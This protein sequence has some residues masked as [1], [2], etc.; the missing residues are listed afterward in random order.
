MPDYPTA[1]AL[2]KQQ[3]AGFL[4][5]LVMVSCAAVVL[6][7]QARKRPRLARAL[8]LA[9]PGLVPLLT[10]LYSPVAA[11]GTILAALATRYAAIP[12][13]RPLWGVLALAAA[14]R[15]PL[16]FNS[17]WYDEAFTSRL[18]HL[19][20]QNLPGAIMADVHPPLYYL[21]LWPL[22]QLTTSP[23]LLRLPSLLAGL[24]AIWLV[25]WLVCGMGLGER[26][27][28]VTSLLWAVLPASIYYATELRSYQLLVVIVLGL[29]LAII[30]NRPRWFAVLLALLPWLHNVGFFYAVV[31]GLVGIAYWHN[32]RWLIA[33]VIGGGI[34]AL[35]LPFLLQQSSKLETYWTYI[36]LGTVFRPLLNMVT[37]E[38]HDFTLVMAVIVTGL[39]VIALLTIHEYALFTGRGL[40]W[41]VL[42]FAVPI[43][44]A[45]V[46]FLWKP[47]YVYRHLLPSALLLTI[48]W[49]FV[50]NRSKLA[51]VMVAPMLALCLF[52]FYSSSVSFAR[53]DY[54]DWIEESCK[55][56]EVGYATSINAAFLMSEN[57]SLPVY[58]WPG[59]TDGG[60]TI[61]PGDAGK[62]NYAYYPLPPE[63]A[64]ILAIEVPA[65]TQAERDYLASLLARFP[66]TASEQIIGDMKQYHLYNID[67][68]AAAKPAPVDWFYLSK[69]Q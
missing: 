27:A 28:T 42:V 29:A 1:I 40:L 23:A 25:Y 15:A 62:F 4:A 30:E 14:L 60:M 8:E 47:I 18:I 13:K 37:Y 12:L 6:Y 36:S 24:L 51:R 34:G 50:L 5:L 3:D 44:E 39:T 35:W 38:S 45:L 41:L 16:L 31:I 61:D 56:A 21:L 59:A 17:L 2:M 64:C 26:V 9:G 54:Q 22:A 19:P 48:A 20:L 67:L 66:Y 55:G 43:L 11:L 32:R 33:G 58:L 52:S 63:R 69:S 57:S 65:T 68:S 53:P 7:W 10:A 49:A 46:S